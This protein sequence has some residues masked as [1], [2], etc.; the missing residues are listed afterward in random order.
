MSLY[1]QGQRHFG[2][3]K[4]QELLSKYE[5]LP[6]DI[7]WHLI[8][9]LQRNKVKYIASFITMIHS[10]DSWELLEEINRQAEKNQR[11]IRILLQV[12]IAEEETKFGLSPQTLN[13]LL[14]RYTSE[15]AR[16]S[17]L[18]VCGLMGMATHT[19]AEEKIRNEFQQLH[20]LFVKM[21][22]Q[23]FTDESSFCELS[24]GMSDDYKLAILEGSTMV[25]IGSALFGARKG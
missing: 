17:H 12:H 21:K 8:G 18:Q 10:V 2:E 4:V 22:Q 6:Q 24:M 19:E 9:H 20:F 16:Y 14:Q 1:Q 7:A 23:F 15:R 11:I 5:V 25:R 3:N 13:N